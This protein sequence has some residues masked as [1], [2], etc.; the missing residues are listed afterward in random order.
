MSFFNFFKQPKNKPR[1]VLDIGSSRVNAVLVQNDPSGKIEILRLFQS[2]SVI[3]PET[4]LKSLWRKMSGSVESL[5][6]EFAKS[7]IKT[8]EA[9]I[10]FSSPWYFSEIRNIEKT[11]DR[12][13]AMTKK[14]L[15]EMLD[16][17]ENS[18]KKDA[19]ARFS[20]NE[21]NAVFARPEIM[22]AKLNGYRIRQPQN[23]VLGKPIEN[24]S[25]ALYLSSFFGAAV[26]HLKRLLADCGIE[27]IEFRSSPHVLFKAFSDNGL[28]DI[29]I[30]DVGGE[31]TDIIMI[32]EGEMKKI[33]SF[34]RGLNYVARR[35]GPVFNVGL[36]ETMA[37]LSNYIEGK[38]DG[39]FK[40][41]VSQI[42]KEALVE[43]Q[44]LFREA[45]EKHVLPDLMPD[46]ILVTGHGGGVIEFK[47]VLSD[48]VFGRY[49]VRGGPFSVVQG[50]P[51][52]SASFK[53]AD[54]VLN[55][56]HLSLI[57]FYLLYA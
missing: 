35:I 49:T 18:F 25:A 36:D 37:M 28:D 51:S 40:E 26:S 46:K 23:N 30:I 9:L 16:A 34:G 14:D 21:E 42:L 7:G 53:N 33:V 29:S 45:L 47:K 50:L 5:V 24:F 55:K 32:K 19:M 44:N 39:S 56:P 3:L 22:G 15:E 38:L 1:L 43:W 10:V 2:E 54:H 41:S 13:T 48:P 4:D 27:S 17:E 57:N 6:S 11:F 20:L 12:P 31:I 52:I 8:D